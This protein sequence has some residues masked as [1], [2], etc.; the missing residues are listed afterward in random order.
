MSDVA[1]YNAF[2]CAFFPVQGA[3]W[4]AVHIAPCTG[5]IGSRLTDV[6]GI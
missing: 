2:L 6:N 5:N 3:M 1:A 4:T